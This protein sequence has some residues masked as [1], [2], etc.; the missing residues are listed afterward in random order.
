MHLIHS[1]SWIIALKYKNGYLTLQ[2]RQTTQS[3]KMPFL[4]FWTT[5][6]KSF[7]INEKKNVSEKYCF[8]RGWEQIFID[9]MASWLHMPQ[10][11][12]FFPQQDH[13]SWGWGAS[14]SLCPRAAQLLSCFSWEP[15][16][17]QPHQE[18]ISW[19]YTWSCDEDI[20]VCICCQSQYSCY[21]LNTGKYGCILQLCI[22][23]IYINMSSKPKLICMDGCVVNSEH[24]VTN[25]L[26]A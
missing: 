14:R 18:W 26:S 9:F 24:F 15:Q 5:F 3:E 2:N 10:G 13:R 21:L 22:T 1:D 8:P 17:M 20:A 12:P 25:A 6:S 19:K 4:S 23:I 16:P 11:T 7:L